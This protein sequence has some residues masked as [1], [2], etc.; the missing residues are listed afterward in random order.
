VPAVVGFTIQEETVIRL[1]A[2]FAHSPVLGKDVE[3]EHTYNQWFKGEVMKKEVVF[4]DK[5]LEYVIR[6]A[7]DNP[8]DPI[9]TFSLEDAITL[10]APEQSI[11][12]LTGLE[13]CLNLQE[14]YLFANNISDISPLAGLSNLEY[15]NL[16]ANNISDISALV[17]DLDYSDLEINNGDMASIAYTEM[18]QPETELRRRKFLGKSLLKYY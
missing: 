16:Y 17:P 6:K 14:L 8:K 5:G 3:L 9:Y 15:L 13:C 4:P 12:D 10:E 18:K 2:D 7:I 1:P 11:S